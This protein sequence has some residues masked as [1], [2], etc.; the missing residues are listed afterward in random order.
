[1]RCLIAAF[2]LALV[3]P[4]TASARMQR[5]TL[6]RVHCGRLASGGTNAAPSP[7][8]GL[9]CVSGTV[10]GLHGR[11]VRVEREDGTRA[12]VLLSNA[13]IFRALSALATFDG[14]EVGD[15]V[16][17]T[18]RERGPGYRALIVLMDVDPFTCDWIRGPD[19]RGGAQRDGSGPA[20]PQKPP[21]HPKHPRAR[22]RPVP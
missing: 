3:L 7:P 19:R 9:Q 12:R 2:M 18:A 11:V 22:W 20:N 1:M 13:T 5:A 15:F 16:C 14:L 6:K 4:G 21:R 8:A 17:V 10:T